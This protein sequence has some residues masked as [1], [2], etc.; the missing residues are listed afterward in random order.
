MPNYA[1]S[2]VSLFAKPDYCSI[3]G[4][5]DETERGAMT[6]EKARPRTTLADRVYQ[7]LFTRISNGEFSTNEKLPAENILSQ[8]FGVS[9]PVLR[10]ALDRLR[11]DG[12]IQS[13]QGAGSY[14]RV[15]LCAPLSFARVET[16][17][18]IQR[19]YE[20]RIALETRAACLAAT[21]H[22]AAALEDV[23]RSLDLLRDAN[24]TM[25]HSDDADFAF[26]LAITKAS[27]NHYFESALLALRDHIYIGMK[28]HGQALSGD[29]DKRLESVF[30]EHT[31]IHA[32]IS[33][34][35]G[36]MASMLML[37]HLENSRE[38]LFGG[39]LVDL[40]MAE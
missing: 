8:E 37:G 25:T 1:D 23:S 27:N 34:R 30:D 22:N 38:R 12:L 3:T 10:V 26:H 19:C 40:R 13:R 5:H 7:T 33:A 36:D 14:V 32:A 6:D 11:D 28:L 2:L 4:E 24:A 15:P 21:C 20:V 29:S 31:A 9:R 17:A 39:G 18:D 35:D 16:L